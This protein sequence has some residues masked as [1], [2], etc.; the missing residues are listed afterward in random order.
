MDPDELDKLLDEGLGSMG[1]PCDPAE[2]EELLASPVAEAAAE[3]NGLVE[4]D[5]ESNA[6]AEPDGLVETVAESDADEE[7]VLMGAS[8]SGDALVILDEEEQPVIR[9]PRRNIMPELVEETPAKVS[10]PVGTGKAH[11]FNGPEQ[12]KAGKLAE[13]KAKIC[14][15]KELQ[16]N[17]L[18]GHVCDDVFRV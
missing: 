10:P 8:S 5:A 17:R 7:P 16:R 3:P 1:S 2:T 15:L 12:D 6:D 11:I 18:P 13:L 4:A 14:K 9:T